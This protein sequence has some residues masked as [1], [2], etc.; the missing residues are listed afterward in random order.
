MVVARV[1]DFV[2]IL[3]AG[4]NA[5]AE[6]HLADLPSRVECVALAIEGMVSSSESLR[7]IV[8]AF[9]VQVLHLEGLNV[10]RT[11]AK[12]REN[13][14]DAVSIY[15]NSFQHIVLG[16][17]PVDENMSSNLFSCRHNPLLDICLFV[18]EMESYWP[19]WSLN[20]GSLRI[21]CGQDVPP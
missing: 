19:I 17:I 3:S 15:R 16:K 18:H 4:S 6:H 8:T 20:K 9:Q 14:E 1:G 5:S 2:L 10:I 7:S 11:K 21:P 13:V 12:V